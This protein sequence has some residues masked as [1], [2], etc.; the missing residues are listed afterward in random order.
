MNVI[1]IETAVKH[2]ALIQF[3]W[4]KFVKNIIL[5]HS[6][7]YYSDCK[8]K[9]EAPLGQNDETAEKLWDLSAKLV[10]L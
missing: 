2:Y 3:F 4:T 9:L 6:G 5:G 1:T 8:E 7:R 10:D